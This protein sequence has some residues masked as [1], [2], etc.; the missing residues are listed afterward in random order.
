MGWR[1]WWCW[2]RGRP[3]TLFVGHHAARTHQ[4]KSTKL[5]CSRALMWRQAGCP[6]TCGLV[7]LEAAQTLQ[8]H[9][10]NLFTFYLLQLTTNHILLSVYQSIP[11]VKIQPRKLYFFIILSKSIS[12]K[13]VFMHVC[14]EMWK[15]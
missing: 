13:P 10:C 5:L 15:I 8:R 2:G 11:S 7:L 14:A 12:I 4:N 3:P 9:V 1:G 6:L